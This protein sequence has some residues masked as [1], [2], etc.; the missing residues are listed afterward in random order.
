MMLG[1]GALS[2]TSAWVL[3]VVAALPVLWW[4]LRLTPPPPK[5]LRFPAVTFLMNLETTEDSSATTPWW[6]VA[7]RL[8]IAS[9]II[10]ALAGPRLGAPI[11]TTRTDP[12]VLVMDDSWAAADQWEERLATAL[13]YVEQAATARREVIIASTASADVQRLPA[14]EAVAQLG[15]WE[16][17]PWATDR[18]TTTAALS[19]LDLETVSY[20]HLRAHETKA[21]LVCRLLL[22][23]KN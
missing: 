3:A 10:V 17:R 6:M 15:R 20:T 8:T 16:P 4:L 13:G 19:E 7:L 2:F 12:L 9:L 21:N 18:K 22:E 14:A 11:D 5:R 1:L 23:Q